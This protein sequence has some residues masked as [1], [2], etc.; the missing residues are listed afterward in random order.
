M[1]DQLLAFGRSE[2]AIDEYIA[3]AD[4]YYSL[5]DLG[6]A[7]KTFSEAIRVA[8]KFQVDRSYRIKILHRMADIDLQSLDW[9][10]ALRIY[11]QI[12]T[13]QPDDVQARTNLVEVNFRLGQ[14][15]RALSELDNYL[16]YL[17]DN[18]QWDKARVFMENL[19]EEEPDRVPVRRRLTDLYK[20]LDQKEEAINQLDAIGEL[21]LEAD[22]KA[23]A[24]QTIEMILDLDPA[25]RVSYEQ[26]LHQLREG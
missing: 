18:N 22:D 9:R 1:I 21:L 5:A 13:L 3:L 26:L 4:V 20:H 7:R 12:R 6:M 17:S 14:E 8:Q 24:I 16:S 11:E 2:E 23:G 15:Q 25:N 19:V 10:Q